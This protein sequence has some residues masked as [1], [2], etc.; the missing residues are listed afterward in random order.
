MALQFHPDPGTIV[1]CDFKGFVP[2]EMVKRRP[3]LVIS[4]RF[5]QRDALC[6]VVPLSTTNPKSICQYHHKLRFDPPLPA[7][8]DAESM[9]V[10]ADMLYAVAFSRLNL[11]QAGTDATTGKRQYDVRHVSELDSRKVH[12][13]GLGS[14][15]QHL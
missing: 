5:R 10:K 9:W 11:P 4:P 14:L 3:D 2:P 8:Y 12:G 13:L 15:A 1:I 6:T 7:P